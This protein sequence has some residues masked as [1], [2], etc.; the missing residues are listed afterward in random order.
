LIKFNLP[1][2]VDIHLPAEGVFHNFVFVSIKKTYPGQAYKVAYAL[3]GMGLM[4]LSKHIIVFDHWVDVHN[5]EE[6]LWIWGN[7]VDPSRDVL[8]LKGPIDV[9]DHSTNE[10]GFGGKMIIDATTKWK[11][12]GYTRQWPEI[13]SVPEDVKKKVEELLVKIFSP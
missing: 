6:V 4:S 5:I 8:I 7:N 11:E 10:V 9:L 1:E 2:V 13:V 3:L 12:E